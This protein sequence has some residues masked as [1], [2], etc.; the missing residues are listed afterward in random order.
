MGLEDGDEE[1]EGEGDGEDE[2]GRKAAGRAGAAA[3][4]GVEALVAVL[5]A[6]R[7]AEEA[8]GGE[9][10]RFNESR[11]S[12]RR[13]LSLADLSKVETALFSL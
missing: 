7:A 13:R 12:R 11:D 4:R 5:S 3:R 6:V 1:E 10:W 9:S 2:Y 8:I